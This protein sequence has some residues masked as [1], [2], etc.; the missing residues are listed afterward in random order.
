MSKFGSW[1]PKNRTFKPGAHILD[2]ISKTK[3]DTNFVGCAL[4]STKLGLSNAQLF[5]SLSRFLA[6]IFRFENMTKNA[7]FEAEIRMLPV[8]ISVGNTFLVEISTG[9]K[10]F[11]NF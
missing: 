1:K 9:N 3:K 6:N 2:L 11:E 4:A 10:K 5:S 7:I 8:E